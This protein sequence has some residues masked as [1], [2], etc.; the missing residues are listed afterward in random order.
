MFAWGEDCRRGFCVRGDPVTEEGVHYFNLGHDVTDLSAG[1][2]VLAFLKCNGNA[3][4][5]RTN[6]GKDGN[7]VR[8]KQKFVKCKEKIEAV[9]CEDDAVLLLSEK[10]SVFCVDTSHTPYTPRILDAFSGIS[11]V[12]VA[13]GSQHSVALTKEGQVYTWG[14]DSRGQLG[15]GKRS[16]EPR[17]PQQVRSLLSTPVVQISAGGDQS[18]ALSVSRG[19]FG[20]G[21]NDCG[22]LGLGDTKDMH[23]PACVHSLNLKKTADICCGKD[24]T[25][26]LTKHGAVF[27]FGS[28]QHGQLGHNSLRNELRPRLVAELWG[29]KVIKIAT[30]RHHT[31]VLTDNQKVYSFGCETQGQLG[32]REETNPSVPLPV[33][34]PRVSGAVHSR[35]GTIF[36]GENC[37]FAACSS[38][39]EVGINSDTNTVSKATRHCLEVV[40]DNWTFK[41]DEKSWRKIRQEIHKTFLSASCLNK[42]FLEERKNKHLKTSSKYHGLNL[43]LARRHFKKLVKTEYVWIEVE[44]AVLRLLPLLDKNPVGVESLRIYLLL[45]ELLHVIQKY[46][47]QQRS[48]LPERVATAVTSLSRESL[49]VLG[50]W[51]A[52]L[53]SSTMERFVSVWRQALCLI[54]SDEDAPRRDGVRNLLQVLQYMYNVNSRVSESRRLPESDFYVMID[55][56]FL[57]SELQ[58]WRLK[59]KRRYVLDEPLVLCNFPIVMDLQTKTVVFHMNTDL[60]KAEFIL[61]MN[62]TFMEMLLIL[63]SG[64]CPKSFYLD[65]HLNRA[66]VLNDTFELLAKADQKDYKKHLVVIFDEHYDPNY[67]DVYAKDF[68]HE[69][70]H[71]L[72]SAESEMFMF[73]DSKTL[74]WFSSAASQEDQRFHLFGVLCGLA[75]YNKVLIYLPFPLVLFKKLLGLRPSLDDL[76]EFSPSYGH[77]LQSILDTEEDPEEMYFTIPWDGTEIDLD[78]ENPDKQVTSENKREFVDAFVSYVFNTSVEVAFYE[79]KRGFFQVC[80]RDLVKLF[81]PKELQETL[82]GKDFHDWEK[83]KQNTVYEGEY[84]ADHPIIQM[85]WEVFDELKESQKNTFLW[86]VTG[87]ERVPILG[88]DKI[89][90]KIKVKTT[91]DD[92]Y[93][94]ATHTCFSTLELPPYSTKDVMRAKLT[95]ALS[96]KRISQCI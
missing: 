53:S 5:L 84:D 6:E 26:V 93:Y 10:G 45:N 56:T 1:R 41:H 49:K 70:F 11:V 50:E 79:F 22:Q 83:L 76:K 19:V 54:L 92:Q 14:L 2:S 51:W 63:G 13:C 62:L 35:I 7:R 37:S 24:H 77:G 8:G 43:K 82:V 28:G 88:L 17:K 66:S 34:L 74:A 18:F 59:S 27:T 85:F 36:A 12:Q 21:R 29:T 42:S 95:E 39:E 30:G 61:S 38:D 31:L 57:L 44:A 71:E 67:I 75:L 47:K 78:P 32:N 94:P 68:F 16:S 72:M 46:R 65:L 33:R 64:C 55:Q 87:F 96:N 73:N 15:Q 90:M 25:V 23:T 91:Q 20:W 60:T 48:R 9:S 3:F 80:D 69:V 40:V 52:S 81:T 4:V 58:I 89:K 86:F